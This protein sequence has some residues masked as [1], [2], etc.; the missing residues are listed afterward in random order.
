[1]HVFLENFREPR[2]CFKVSSRLSRLCLVQ[3]SRYLSVPLKTISLLTT[4]AWLLMQFFPSVFWHR[5]CK[6]VA[7]SLFCASLPSPVRL[8]IWNVSETVSL[9]RVM[10]SSPVP[11]DN[12]GQVFH[13]SLSLPIRTSRS[14]IKARTA[15]KH[16]F[17][18]KACFGRLYGFLWHEIIICGV[19]PNDTEDFTFFCDHDWSNDA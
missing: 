4:N 17:R 15:N 7:R 18:Q 13:L 6:E 9:W 14:I 11:L 3:F 19:S 12:E 5:L 8:Q 1:M 2:R 16:N 10:L